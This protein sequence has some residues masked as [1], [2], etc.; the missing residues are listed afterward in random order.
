LEVGANEVAGLKLSGS[1]S[2]GWRLELRGWRLEQSEVGGWSFDEVGG[3][4]Y[5]A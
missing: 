5:D 3:W 1:Y 4:S 2:R